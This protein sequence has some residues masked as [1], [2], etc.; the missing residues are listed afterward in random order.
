MLKG[1]SMDRNEVEAFVFW[2][3]TTYGAEQLG[4][5]LWGFNID[6][7][8]QKV[9]TFLFIWDDFWSVACPFMQLDKKAKSQLFE[10][11]EA[12]SDRS[13]M[14]LTIIGDMLCIVN[15]SNELNAYE[16]DQWIQDFANHAVELMN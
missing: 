11:M 7:D 9:V 14:G 5:N 10:I 1:E 16:A 6:I 3:N 2:F 12:H 15:C 4:D 8:G 13:A